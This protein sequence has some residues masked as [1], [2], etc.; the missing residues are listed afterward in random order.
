[1]IGFHTFIRLT[2]N[3]FADK[4]DMLKKET[5]HEVQSI[6]DE[7]DS[8]LFVT[9]HRS[10]PIM[11]WNKNDYCVLIEGAIYNKSDEIIESELNNIVTNGLKKDEIDAFVSDSDGDYLVVIKNVR[12]REVVIF[13]DILGNIPLNFLFTKDLF[14][15]SRS[16]SY[17]AAN[18]PELYISTTNFAEFLTLDFNLQNHT[19]FEGVS[20]LM[21]AQEIR[22]KEVDGSLQTEIRNTYEHSFEL[23][24]P[25]RNKKEAAKELAHL[26]IKGCEN[27]IKYAKEHGYNIVNTMSGGFDSR[28]V[29][30]GIEKYLDTYTNITY[31]YKQ[32]ESEVAKEVLEKVGSKSEFIKFSFVNKADYQNDRLTYNTDGKINCYTNSVCYN[33]LQYGYSHY[34]SGKKVLYFGGFGGEFIRHPYFSSAWNRNNIWLR[35]FSPNINEV[36]NI[37]KTD[38]SDVSVIK[39]MF[40]SI[41]ASDNQSYCK[42]FYSEYYTKFV[43][44]AGEDRMR[45]F[46]FTVQPLMAKDFILAARNRVPLKW[47]GYVFYKLFLSAINPRL[48]EVEIWGGRPNIHSLTSLLL[49]DYRMK[50]YLIN[51]IKFYILNKRK[52]KGKPLYGRNLL[53][54]NLAQNPYANSVIDVDYVI[55]NYYKLGGNFQKKLL[56]ALQYLKMVNQERR[57]NS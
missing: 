42:K 12:K 9:R 57:N 50:G 46:Y 1:M 37:L 32:D 24:N 38:N 3:A 11:F 17:I 14:V 33:D 23:I 7:K 2:Q 55:N 13:N 39:K 25:F 31:E 6:V 44:G 19:I 41:S 54:R 29:L 20:Q 35:F 49:N 34:F 36:C 16:L 53:E 26:F 28:T 21:P 27:R 5:W 56:A 22:C 4:R 48:N 45:M 43:R 52:Y 10:Y 47:C 18:I 15:A 8:P 51:T 30:G 40:K